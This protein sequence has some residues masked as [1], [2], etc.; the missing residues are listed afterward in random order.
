MFSGEGGEDPGFLLSG[1]GGGRVVCGR[2]GIRIVAAPGGG[3]EDRGQSAHMV[4][5]VE[6]GVMWTFRVVFRTLQMGLT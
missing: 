1:T 5:V 6:K 2:G 3:D 4:V